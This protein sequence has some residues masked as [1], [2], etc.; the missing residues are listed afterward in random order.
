MKIIN[1]MKC[2]RIVH[3]NS[4]H[5]PNI[6]I[7]KRNFIINKVKQRVLTIN[8]LL[9]VL[10]KLIVS[11]IILTSGLYGAF[12]VSKYSDSGITGVMIGYIIAMLILINWVLDYGFCESIWSVRWKH[13]G[14][15]Y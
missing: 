14:K 13:K 5:K 3:C 7:E 9:N 1:P 15:K 10:I 11:L 6:W 4:Y 8:K 12:I 2:G